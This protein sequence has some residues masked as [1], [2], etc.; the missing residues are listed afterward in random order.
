MSKIVIGITDG[1]LYENYA[2]WIAMDGDVELV[3]LGHNFNNLEDI[4]RCQGLFMTGGEDVHPRLYNNPAYVEQFK[5]SDFDERRDEFEMQLLAHW[6]TSKMPLLGVCRGLQLVNVFLGGTLIPDL[7]SFGKFNHSRML[8]A[9]RYHAV[10]VDTNSQL[11]SLLKIASGE[12]TSIHHQSVDRIAQGLVT[13]TITADGVIEGAEWLSPQGKVPMIL[14]QWHPEAM[15]D[16]GSPF[17]K[18]IRKYFVK[19]VQDNS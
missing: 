15:Q 1:R 10:Q 12:V 4:K 5:L 3:R 16:K 19:L 9:P 7:P 18:N 6:Q 11:F 14:I 2:N 13:N 17:S 8:T